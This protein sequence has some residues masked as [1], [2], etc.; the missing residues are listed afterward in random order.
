MPHQLETDKL[1]YESYERDEHSITLIV[2]IK[3]IKDGSYKVTFGESTVN[4]VFQTSNP[5]LIAPEFG[6]FPHDTEFS[7]TIN[8]K[9]EIVPEQCS[10]NKTA[11]K[12]EVK[13]K[14]KKPLKWDTIEEAKPK[15][16]KDTLQ[17]ID[18]RKVPSKRNVW[19]PAAPME[20][21]VDI[22]VPNENLYNNLGGDI[23]GASIP[24]PPPEEMRS[25]TSKLSLSSFS[26]SEVGYTGLDNLGN[27]C[28]MNAVLQCLS[29]TQELRDYFMENHFKEDLNEKNVFGTGGQLAVSFAVLMK[30]LWSGA[31]PSY[32]PSKLKSLLSDKLSQFSGFAQHDAQEYMSFLLD[33]LHEDINRVRHKA[34]VDMNGTDDEEKPRP[35]AEIADEAW[36][37]YRMRNDS[38]IIDL[39]HGQ[40][41]SKVICPVR[42]NV[43]IT[44]DP[45]V[46]LPLP[47]PKNQLIYNVFFF[48]RDT[49]K[50]PIR[51]LVK[52]PQDSE[53]R[54]LL[55]SISTR[56]SVLPSNLRALL[57]CN[58]SI[59][60]IF[61][62]DEAIP[63]ISHNEMLLIFETLNSQDLGEDVYEFAVQQ[64]L[65]NSNDL[66]LW[67]SGCNNALTEKE[68]KRC[69]KCYQ[70]YYCDQECQKNDWTKH[71]EV[72]FSRPELI[73][74][75]FIISI[76]QSQFTFKNLQQ[77][78][79]EYSRFS[80]DI[81]CPTSRS[82]S[83]D[84]CPET[85]DSDSGVYSDT[86]ENSC[87]S[88]S[89]SCSNS[90]PPSFTAPT[91]TS[92]STT[93]STTSSPTVTQ[94][95][96]KFLLRY[97]NSRCFTR[98]SD[99][100]LIQEPDDENEES[101]MKD[102]SGKYF[103]SMEWR[104]LEHKNGSFIV[105]TKD[106]DHNYDI[107]EAQRIASECYEHTL[108]DC[109][110]AFIEPEILSA[111]EAW[112]CPSCKALREATKQLCLWRLPPILIIQ[113]KRFM[114]KNLYYKE[115]IS[116][117]IRFPLENL[118][119][120]EYCCP[121]S[122]QVSQ[123]KPIY[124]LYA[125]INHHGGMFGGHYTAYARTRFKN[126]EY[127]WRCFDDS[128][129]RDMHPEEVTTDN[130]YILFYRLRE[131]KINS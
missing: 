103:L 2:Y 100:T 5:R 127:G 18:L 113:L 20:D 77:M 118:D 88:S 84:D 98:I 73:G 117:F 32:S 16:L 93:T 34:N 102:L 75:P 53:M 92:S 64:L 52:L 28:F 114:F 123:Q 21:D 112:Y 106:L 128:R 108:Q 60:N 70:A 29:N 129:V 119:M 82:D 46:I 90:I 40:L 10:Y 62:P 55:Q 33:A 122:P 3:D 69:T 9:K 91:L 8:L 15:V 86:S 56:T 19:I 63:T 45:F 12:L 38:V 26:S 49:S 42:A 13:L 85:K 37:K 23:Y 58:G 81:C 44:F 50:K 121:N 111:D 39:F 25:Y 105:E 41:R 43:S 78:V 36:Y 110:S 83:I 67:C 124:D 115:K 116:K 125:V 7:W 59:L 94:T 89:T 66:P 131:E 80:V 107:L 79:A 27:T 6:D 65:A 11:F 120:T 68:L 1:R 76:P 126:R 24:L 96:P 57:T 30:H 74:C 47:M 97:H 72:C 130:A 61:K 22:E 109:L 104:P 54:C 51:Y 95:R 99:E 35:D 17:E 87:S 101:I 71:K 31:H 14:K 4:I 48:S